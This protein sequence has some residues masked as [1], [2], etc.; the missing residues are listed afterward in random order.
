MKLHE[1]L[2]KARKEKGLSQLEVAEAMQVSRQ[3]VSRWEVGS[4]APSVENLSLLSELYGVSLDYLIKDEE[5]KFK[6]EEEQGNKSEIST[7]QRKNAIDNSNR[8]TKDNVKKETLII[9][10]IVFLLIAVVCIAVILK[11]TNGVS[12]DELKTEQ[13]IVEEGSDKFNFNNMEIEKID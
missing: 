12:I 9:T 6:P 10:V 11:K 13:S 8:K 4:T 3:A 2:S 7:L 1:K 5:E